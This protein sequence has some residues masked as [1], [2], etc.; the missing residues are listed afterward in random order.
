M[1][2]EELKNILI[3]MA[4]AAPARVSFLWQGMEETSSWAD[5]EP[6]KVMVSVAKIW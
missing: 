3:D 4:K 2:R 6:E 1:K 5:Y